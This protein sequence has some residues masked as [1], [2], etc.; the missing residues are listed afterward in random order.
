MNL[1]NGTLFDVITTECTLDVFHTAI[2]NL[3]AGGLTILTIGVAFVVSYKN[4]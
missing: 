3:T 1:G 2:I 4:L